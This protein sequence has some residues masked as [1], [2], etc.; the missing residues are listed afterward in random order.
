METRRIMSVVR[1]IAVLAGLSVLGDPAFGQGKSGATLSAD[2]TLDI[3][4]NGDGTWAYSG[5]VSVWNTGA[6]NATG[7]RIYDVIENK[8]SGPK[9]TSQYV[10]LDNVSCGNLSAQVPGVTPE[11]AAFVTTYSVD[12][13]PLSGTIRNNAQ[14][15]IDNHSGGRADGPNP[16]FTYTGPI[17]PPPCALPLGCGCALTQGYWKTH[18]DDPA[19]S[20]AD[21]SVFGGAVNALAILKTAPKGN[22]WY[23]LADQYIAYLLNV[24][25]EDQPACTPA[26][27]HTIV[28]SAGN[29]FTS[30]P[31]PAAACPTSSSCGTQKADACILDQYNQG[32]YPDGPMHCGGVTDD[33][34]PL[35]TTP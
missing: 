33:E 17:P 20:T 26:G 18:T 13:A 21:L 1:G 14:V 4:D 23:I 25:K 31:D 9:F 10:A 28:T 7:C 5:A 24:G 2:K 3:C 34:P 15:T 6:N 32:A 11:D 8:V 16:K 27:L 19:W 35:C 22:G 12:G 29:F 30:N